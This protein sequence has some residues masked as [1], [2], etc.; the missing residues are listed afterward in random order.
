MGGSS[1]GGGGTQTTTTNPNPWSGA[2]PY[3][4]EGL[5]NL[6]QIYE[7]GHPTGPVTI[8]GATYAGSVA[9][10]DYYP[11]S[12]VASMSPWTQ[13]AL[14][15]QAQRGLEG[16]PLT[17]ASQDELT[18]TMQGS[19]LHPDSNPYLAGTIDA[20]TRPI[21]ENFRDVVMPGVDS[22][23]SSA[24]RYGSAA[25]TGAARDATDTMA[26]AV[27]EAGT[28]LAYQN[29]GD[30]RNR[31]QQGMVWAPELAKQDY[32]DINQVGASGSAI[33]AYNQALINEDVERY[34]YGQDADWQRTLQFLQG[35]QGVAP[36]GSTS[37]T[38]MPRQDPFQSALGAG[39]SGAG[40][41][42]LFGVI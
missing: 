26:R 25:H 14:A 5:H 21:V 16:S 30:E 35:I 33:D 20:A 10:P 1:K 24:G 11:Q 38:R 19:Y 27:G 40:I 2:E 29:Y 22:A 36:F 6:Q 15:M 42:K 17:R 3:L 41:L 9:A 8:N 7:T 32:F 23:F 13:Q 31:Q 34:N 37:T 18:R 4:R 39:L 12:T 28:R